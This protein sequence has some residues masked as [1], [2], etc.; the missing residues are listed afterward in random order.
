M[1]NYSFNCEACDHKFELFLKMSECE[2]PLKEKCPKC[3]K[4]KVVRDWADQTNSI[5]IDTTLTPSK[6]NGSAWKEVI[7]KIKNS[8]HVPKRYHDKL[9]NSGRHAG[10]YVR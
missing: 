6:V 9:E 2:N 3:K 10:R 7:D 4:K 8:G 5:A 1:P